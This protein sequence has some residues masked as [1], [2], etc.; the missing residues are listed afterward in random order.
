MTDASWVGDGAGALCV[1]LILV[2]LLSLS[3]ATVRLRPVA[4]LLPRTAKGAPVSLVRPVCGLEAY[5]E[6][7]LASGFRLDYPDYELIFCVARG[8]DPVV[9]LVERLRA[10]HPEIPSQLLIGDVKVSG[11]PKL[12]NCVR[13]WEAARHNWVVLADSNVLMPTDYLQRLL[14][15][16][17]SDTGL[18]CSTPAGSRPNGFWAEVE[19]AFL[20]TLQA[21]W[22]YVGEAFGFGFA[23]GKSMLWK[24]PF[25]DARGGIRALAAEIAEDAAATKL[26]RAAGLRVHL[27]DAPFEQ[28]LGPRDAREIIDRQFRWARLRRVTFPL[29]FAP[30][31]F[32]GAAVPLATGTYAAVAA[33]WSPLAAVLVILVL[34]YGPELALARR[35]GWFVSWRLPLAC[36][37]RDLVFP[38]IWAYA[39]IADG[40]VW[41][42][43]AMTIEVGG[44]TGGRPLRELSTGFGVALG[45]RSVRPP[46]AST[47]SARNE[48]GE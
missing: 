26:V 2:N 1:L 44:G 37:T 41:R 10:A 3:V 7:T 23:Q 12:N 47:T 32:A 4:G 24:K 34:W 35:M 42:G 39:F 36:L 25:L 31:I 22:Q 13:G 16:W 5:S 48:F 38:F 6:E 17:R 9:P 29:F 11:N 45:R 33:G 46:P 14:S 40:V 8:D 15:A 30:E 18:V 20:N 19:C 27:V 28:P 43:N 21:R